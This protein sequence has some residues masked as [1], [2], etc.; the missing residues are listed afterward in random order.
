[1]GHGRPVRAPRHHRPRRRARART[2][3]RTACGSADRWVHLRMCQTCGHVGCCDSSP[4]RHA[5]AHVH[6]TG[7]PLVRSF[8]PDEEWFWC[9]VD[10]VVFERPEAPAGAVPLLRPGRPRRAPITS[11]PGRRLPRGRAARHRLRGDHA[12]GGQ[13]P[14]RRGALP[15]PARVPGRRTG[16]HRHRPGRER[17]G[18]TRAGARSAR[19]PG[20]RGR[21]RLRRRDGRRAAGR[22]RPAA[23]ARVAAG[24]V[25][26]HRRRPAGRRGAAR[27]SPGHHALG[28]RG[29]P[30]RPVPAGGLRQRPDLHR[31]GRRV[32]LGGR[33][34]RPGPDPRLRRG[35]RRARAGA[36][37][38]AAARDLSPASR[39]P[40]PDEHVHGTA[41]GPPLGG[42]GRRRPRH[43]PSRR[44]P[45]D[46][47]TG[48]PRRGQRAPPGPPVPAG[49]RRDPGP[50]RAAGPDRGGGPP[51]GRHRPHRAG[52]GHPVRV[53]DR[54][55]AAARVRR[56]VRRLAVPLPRDPVA[57]RHRRRVSGYRARSARPPRPAP[58]RRPV[59]GATRRSRCWSRWRRG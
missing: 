9:Y 2:A 27:R 54:R 24:G 35:R 20:R 32:H 47:R 19:H 30:A 44:R 23:R 36:G 52:R 17:R 13:P 16:P 59:R 21:H 34:R 51:A 15:P 39:Q 31:R 41:R 48:D 12:A 43:R 8:E 14:A 7:H 28:P 37:G 46:G 58:G 49:G 4:R 11:R 22:A 26:V 53:R 56:P 38:G 40:G 5:T 6:D 33:D 55:G 45:V 50:V 1:M 3:A 42:A 29:V 57:G 25:G 18:S 10:E